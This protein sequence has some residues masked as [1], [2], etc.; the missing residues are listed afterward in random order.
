M[1]SDWSVTA[2]P[3]GVGQTVTAT[4]TGTKHVKSVSYFKVP[5]VTAPTAKLGLIYTGS[6]QELVNAGTTT[7]GTMQYKVNE[8]EWSTTVPSATNA[9]TYTI[10]YRVQADETYAGNAGGSFE[11]TIA[12]ATP[13]A[14]TLSKTSISFGADDF[15]TTFTVTRTGD[16]AISVSSN[17]SEV[18]CTLSGNTVTVRRR[19][20]RPLSDITITVKIEGVICEKSG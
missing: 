15:T 9:G 5:V 19:S 12:K 4:Y 14:V 18:K 7:G 17:N 10:Y 20:G 6:A 2:S 16:G 11:V 8:G 13:A 3:V 1:A